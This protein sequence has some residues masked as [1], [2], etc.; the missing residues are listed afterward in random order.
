MS[1]GVNSSGRANRLAR[2]TSPYLLQHAFNPVDWFAW[3]EEA[4]EEARRRDVPIFLSIGYSTCYWCHVMERESFEHGQT[5][6][7]MNEKFVC[8]KL[9]REERPDLDELYMSATVLMRGHG[10]WPMSVFLE[11]DTLRPFFCGTYFPREAGARA[12]GPLFK[13][14][15]E[16]MSQAYRTQRG[17]VREQAAQLARAVEE[18][19][20]SADVSRTSLG[21]QTVQEALSRVL[22]M[23]DRV[24]GGFGVAPKFPQPV[25]LE[26]LLD[27]RDAVDE[28]TRVAVDLAIR[29]TLDAMAK[30]GIH[31]HLGGGLHR[32]SVDATWTVP[33]F[34][35][36]LYDQ[37]QL[38]SV[39]ARGAAVYDDA[40]YRDVCAGIVSYLKREMLDS[41]GGFFSAQDAEVDGREG[42]N[43]LWTP[44]QVRGV[45]GEDGEFAVRVFGLDEQTNFSDPHHPDADPAWVLRLRARPDHLA[46]EMGM[47]DGEFEERFARVKSKML[48]ER[49]GRKQPTTDTKILAS[50][51]CMMACGL[52]VCGRLLK[53]DDA[54]T[55][56]RETVRAVLT[57][58]VRGNELL[59]TARGEHAHT[60]A[61]LEDYAWAV[62]ACFAVGFKDEAVRLAGEMKELFCASIEVAHPK[63]LPERGAICRWFD[64][65]E[66]QRDVFVRA[67]GTHDGASPSGFACAVHAL[68]DAG[69]V[70][71]TAWALAGQSARIA[72]SP[73]GC[74]ESVRGL[75]RLLR[76]GD[77]QSGLQ[78]EAAR[79]AV[80]ML[81]GVD[82]V[83][84]GSSR[85]SG[86]ADNQ[87]VQD[88]V[89]IFAST[90]RVTVSQDTPG[91]I[92]L[93]VQVE[94]G[95][96]V[97][98]AQP[99]E[100]G[101][102]AVALVPFRVGVHNG[103]G[104]AVYADY[105]KGELLAVDAPQ[106]KP[107]VY[108]GRLEIPV[109]IERVG[110][111]S[112][113]PLLTVAYQACSDNACFE[114]MV[115]E[116]DIAIDRG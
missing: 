66:Q 10:G 13:Q 110:E 6:A 93:V 81:A 12:G 31:D 60:R 114:P 71:G 36:M 55:L 19:L 41:A 44:E 57:R 101:N 4:F 40:L 80:Q 116:L 74:I 90:E 18:H 35:K 43:Y 107:R 97:I 25:F 30:G 61:F 58:L 92:T 54:L 51:N 23:F 2:S 34:E 87:G 89:Q 37:A 1:D 29:T 45:C 98:A 86:P 3:G 109:V 65:R 32:Y 11:P 48:A 63:P 39:Y 56:A 91:L 106:G 68:L 38:L 115:V 73:A 47:T 52:E 111:W 49:Q 7:L 77:R 9:D 26:F 46:R 70:D 50:W 85:R 104:V 53:N 100:D 99:W 102:A 21:V 75:L 59:R 112:G 105:P 62:R 42:L 15:L 5:A 14:V 103:S 27:A 64:T 20:G 16:G 96:H 84:A 108:A 67:C 88:V 94:A 83:Q 17:E 79:R 69:D 82:G 78:H 28:Q 33:H 95:H 22:A 8:V 24:R 72:A 113:S 76:T